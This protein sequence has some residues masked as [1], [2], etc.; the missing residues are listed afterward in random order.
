MRAWSGLPN[1]AGVRR[2]VRIELRRK[3]KKRWWR[4]GRSIQIGS[5][6][7]EGAVAAAG[8]EL[9]RSTIH[10]ILLRHGLVHEP[11][12]PGVAAQRFEREMPNE[13]WQ[14]D[15]KGPLCRAERVGPLSV[16][17]DRQGRYLLL[18][19]KGGQHKCRTGGRGF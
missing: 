14:M 2:G 10:R 15:F 12:H 5:A 8:I 4:C 6:Q 19:Q 18:L 7:A 1:A 13:L 3:W 16:L 9:A 11:E 17:D